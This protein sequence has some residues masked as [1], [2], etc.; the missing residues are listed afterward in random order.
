MIRKRIVIEMDANEVSGWLDRNCYSNKAN[1]VSVEDV[2]NVEH[3]C[4]C[5]VDSTLSEGWINC[6]KC[7]KGYWFSKKGN[8][9][10]QDVVILSS[11]SFKPCPFCGSWAAFQSTINGACRVYCKNPKCGIR[12]EARRESSSAAAEEWNRRA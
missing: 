7:G 6:D 10:P 1:S 5:T 9:P 2:P 3:S 4:I 8:P 11:K 12:P